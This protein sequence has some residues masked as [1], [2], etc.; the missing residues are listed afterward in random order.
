MK[1]LGAICL[2][3]SALEFCSGENR[4]CFAHLDEGE[5]LAKCTATGKYWRKCVKFVWNQWKLFIKS[6]SYDWL[7][8]V[9]A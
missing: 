3:L 9:Q 7:T 4:N 2:V 1:L 6:V 5:A 8:V